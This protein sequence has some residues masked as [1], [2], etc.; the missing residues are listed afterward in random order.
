MSART[1]RPRDTRDVLRDEKKK[2]KK[3]L[4]EGAEGKKKDENP[5]VRVRVLRKRSSRMRL[6]FVSEVKRD[7]PSGRTNTSA[8]SRRTR[9]TSPRR[10]NAG[11]GRRER[12][13]ERSQPRRRLCSRRGVRVHTHVGVS[14]CSRRRRPGFY[15]GT[16]AA[17]APG[18][19]WC[20]RDPLRGI[21]SHHQDFRINQSFVSRG[22]AGA[23]RP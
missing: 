11:T 7:A 9:A 17:D 3:N 8:S 13:R 14:R 23:P 16:Y 18:I 2:K 12:E 15:T 4:G 5:P 21:A 19:T 1:P 22:S 6:A 10:R 20:A